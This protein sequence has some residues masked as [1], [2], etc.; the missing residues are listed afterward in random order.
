MKLYELAN[1]E[2]TS[3]FPSLG[4]VFRAGLRTRPAFPGAIQVTEVEVSDDL[5]HW[6]AFL[7]GGCPNEIFRGRAWVLTPRGRFMRAHPPKL[8][9]RRE[10]GGLLALLGL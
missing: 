9:R 2:R 8:A 6:K 5:A 7:I 1:G 4:T 10:V 3:W